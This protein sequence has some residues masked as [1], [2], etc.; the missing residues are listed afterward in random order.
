MPTENLLRTDLQH[1]IYRSDLDKATGTRQIDDDYE[2]QSVKYQA[3]PYRFVTSEASRSGDI[4]LR[5][6]TISSVKPEQM[7]TGKDR[8]TKVDGAVL[9]VHKNHVLCEIY[10]DVEQNRKTQITLHESLFPKDIHCGSP[11]SLS[12]TMDSDGIRRPLVSARQMELS[13]KM[14]AENKEIDSIIED[15]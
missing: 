9:R 14:V 8:K 6:D 3:L 15:L 13:E 7:L 10:L 4:I 2:G 11:I 5:S 12:Y 1:V